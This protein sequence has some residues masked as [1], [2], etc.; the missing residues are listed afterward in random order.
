MKTGTVI[1]LTSIYDVCLQ[2]Y[3]DGKKD[4]MLAAM[5]GALLF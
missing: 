4:P 1:I 5:S 2:V 3:I